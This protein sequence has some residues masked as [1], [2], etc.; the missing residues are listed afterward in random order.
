MFFKT[1]VQGR[2][3]FGTQKVYDKVIKMFQY[4]AE[5]Y[6]K[7]E[8][9]FEEED[10]FIEEEL[11][12]FI[13]RFVGQ[14]SHKH[15]KNTTRL[16]EYCGQFAVTGTIKAWL[17]DEGKVLHYSLTEPDSDKVVVQSYLKGKSLVKVVGKEDEAI[18]ALNKA[19]EKY[20]R[21][22]QAYERRGKVNFIMKKY[23]DAMRDYNKS[24]SIDHTNPHSH[25]GRAKVNLVEKRYEDA[26]VDFDNALKTSVAL[27][28]LYWKARRLKAKAHIALEQWDKAAFDLKLFTNKK[29]KKN[30]SNIPWKR[31]AYANYAF[32][33]IQNEE[34]LEAIKAV[35][36]ALKIEELNDE[37]EVAMLIR[38]RGIAKQK[39]GKSGFKKDFKD[40]AERGDKEAKK[41]L[42]DSKK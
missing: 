30:D 17:I 14:S 41:L 12:L 31:Q 8:I 26:I 11:C 13:P 36:A 5:N 25:F 21:H 28:G 24:I 19:I 18:A 23:H 16:L 9:I 27:Q 15:F 10:I 40:A 34:Y 32:V 35:E 3:E 42:E 1:I 38:Y 4:R 20:D 6:H 33:L 29:F 2:L 7:N 22:A 37:I 39:A